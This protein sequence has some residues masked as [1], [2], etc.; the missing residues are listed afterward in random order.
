MENVV[1]LEISIIA[2]KESWYYADG[3][4]RILEQEISEKY[5]KHFQRQ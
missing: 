1:P 5:R 4:S 3:R 2:T